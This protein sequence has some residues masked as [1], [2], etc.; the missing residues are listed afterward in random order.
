[1]IYNPKDEDDFTSKPIKTHNEFR[2]RKDLITKNSET[3]NFQAIFQVIE[4]MQKLF[5]L[6]G[7]IPPTEELLATLSNINENPMLIYSSSSD[8]MNILQYISNE[9]E[10]DSPTDFLVLQVLNI[11]KILLSS[12]ERYGDEWYI[13]D[14]PEKIQMIMTM[15][16]S[17]I[18]SIIIQIFVDF[19]AEPDLS[20]DKL[21]Y[22]CE[23]FLLQSEQWAFANENFDNR[24]NCIY[25]IG[26]MIISQ[27]EFEDQ[28]FLN[29]LSLSLNLLNENN[30][31]IFEWASWLISLSLRFYDENKPASDD[32]NASQSAPDN[33]DT[34]YSVPIDASQSAP[35]DNDP[36]KSAYIDIINSFFKIINM[37]DFGLLGTQSSKLFLL[38]L[39]KHELAPDL[40]Q[41]LN[42]IILIQTI[43]ESDDETTITNCLYSILY[44]SDKETELIHDMMT[45]GLLDAITKS[46]QL[47]YKAQLITLGIIKNILINGT[48]EEKICIL[49]NPSTD[50][51][52]DYIDSGADINV[53]DAVFNAMRNAFQDIQVSV[54]YPHIV[55]E[56]NEK[57]WTEK[58]NEIA[59]INELNL[60]DSAIEIL[61]CLGVD[62]EDE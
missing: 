5:E 51:V 32:E 16:D 53:G 50:Q 62:V 29:I 27:V 40:L 21:V 33:I 37:E 46:M 56:Y 10:I 6:S 1:M 2:D 12:I 44:I 35:D 47:N 23:N 31:V 57:G 42:Y 36:Y 8:F 61:K 49:T 43:I 59:N 55:E 58:I 26:N 11:I 9:L 22:L 13:L 3:E 24:I 39:Y 41:D 17:E 30:R 14:I 38:L 15:P 18:Q 60:Q 52:L 7:N 54:Y 45:N 4:D 34:S 19:S 25:F 20:N 28:D 48:D